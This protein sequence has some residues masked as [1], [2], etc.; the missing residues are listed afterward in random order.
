MKFCVEYDEQG[1]IKTIGAIAVDPDGNNR[2]ELKPRHGYKV[3]TVEIPEIT[4][5]KDVERLLDIQRNYRVEEYQG[6]HRLVNK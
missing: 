4:D 5:A 3:V 2:M 6:R 1:T